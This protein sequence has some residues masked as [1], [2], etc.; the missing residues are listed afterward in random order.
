MMM[1]G[2]LIAFLILFV[3][4]PASAQVRLGF[5]GGLNLAN[6]SV[7]PDEGVDL[8]SRTVFGFGG[9]LEYC[10]N[11][12][13][14]LKLEPMF[15]QKGSKQEVE[16][17]EGMEGMEAELKLSYLELPVLVSYAFGANNVKPYIMAG[18][19]IGLNLSA[20]EESSVLGVSVEVDLKDLDLIKSIDFGL[21]FGAGVSF[22]MGK[23]SVFV[24][25]RYALGLTNIIDDPED[26][27]AEM[28]TKGIQ[29]FAGITFP[30]GTS[31]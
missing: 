5:L 12:S 3:G 2:V 23:N 27:G 30:L 11:E 6:V 18:P 9:I 26:T 1:R 25:G 19:T 29:V 15:L 20:K 8:S 16:G 22:P 4:I 21:G 13:F 24:E 7:D 17:M 14:S 28:K 10:V 31:Q